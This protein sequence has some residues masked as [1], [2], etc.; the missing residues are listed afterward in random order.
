MA[1]GVGLVILHGADNAFT[2]WVEYE[3][4]IGLLFREG[5]GHGEYHEFEVKI[6]D[7]DHPRAVELP[8]MGRTVPQA[9]PAARGRV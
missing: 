7:G 3:K 1:G 5:S 4:M 9:F 6:T 8:H 2:G